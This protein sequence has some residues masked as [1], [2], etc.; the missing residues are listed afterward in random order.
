VPPSENI[1]I[2]IITVCQNS[3]ATIRDT[4]ASVTAQTYTNIEY[5]IIDGGSNDHTLQIVKEYPETVTQSLSE[6]DHGIYDAMNKGIKRATGEYV[7]F[8]NSDDILL[9]D[10]V[11]EDAAKAISA[12]RPDIV[13]GD[14]AVFN[15]TSGV[16]EHKKQKDLT[17]IHVFKNM[18]CQPSVLYRR[19][20]FSKCGM[21]NTAYRIV[22]DFDWM[23]NA[24]LRYTVSLQYIGIALIRF[25]T[26]GISSNSDSTVHDRERLEVY[27]E[28]FSPSERVLYPFI[29]RYFRTLTTLPIVSNILNCF[30]NIKLKNTI[31]Q[32][33][34]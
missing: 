18:P 31:L 12:N 5:I 10:R 23:T 28:Y 21:F 24:I 15:P 25:R 8:L 29:S 33:N 1:L 7:L 17:R 11:I 2:S 13:F 30:V 3:E 14:M 9:H 26:G 16:T 27:Q 6:S 32:S 19:S 20:V 34:K 22:S 4:L